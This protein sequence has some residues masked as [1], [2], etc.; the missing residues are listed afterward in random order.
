MNIVTNHHWR[1][2][3]YREDV[4]EKI[5]EDDFD[6]TNEDHEES[7]DYLGSIGVAR[8][9]PADGFIKYQG[10]HYHLGEFMRCHGELLELGWEGVAND[11]F[12]S[13]ILIKVSEDG[14]QYQIARIWI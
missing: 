9:A 2:F 6:W 10:H 5:L 1:A 3:V 14:E 8:S 12:F 7:D 11:T 4:P 13:G